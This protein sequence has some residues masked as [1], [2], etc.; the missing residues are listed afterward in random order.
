MIEVDVTVGVGRGQPGRCDLTTQV[1]R[2]EVT[3]PR[4]LAEDR[5]FISSS[6][7]TTMHV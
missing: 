2:R 7:E 4:S 6:E 3:T 5:L 1:M